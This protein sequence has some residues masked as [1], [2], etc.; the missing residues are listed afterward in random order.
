MENYLYLSWLWL[1]GTT[2]W[3]NDPIE[4]DFRF[5]QMLVVL[6]KVINHDMEVFNLLFESLN[7]FYEEDKIIKLYEKLISYRINP[8]Q[9]IYSIVSKIMDKKKIKI[10]DK[11]VMLDIEEKKANDQ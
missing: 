10:T 2:Y 3:Y 6:D 8:S 7:K 9:Y 5:K 11:K 4:K 1:W